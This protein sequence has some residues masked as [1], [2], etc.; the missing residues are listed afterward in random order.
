MQLLAYSSLP[1]QHISEIQYEASNHST[2][3]YVAHVSKAQRQH[4]LCPMVPALR[5]PTAPGHPLT[6]PSLAQEQRLHQI[7]CHLFHWLHLMV[8]SFGSLPQTM[9]LFL[10]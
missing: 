5:A 9:A 10:C 1:V 3:S 8:A 4:G 7:H 2:K 6:L